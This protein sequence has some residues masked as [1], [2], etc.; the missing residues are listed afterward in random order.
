MA[1]RYELKRS[2]DDQY[3]FNLV[4]ANNE[5]ILSSE[6]YTEKSSAKS[7]IESC[8]ANSY[9]DARY[10]RRTASSGDPYFVLKAANNQVIG[11]SETCS[12]TQAMENGIEACKRVGTDAPISDLT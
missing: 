4:A 11:R 10:D 12:S 5:T 2:S 3:F 7:G 9:I 8:R 6:R 1:A